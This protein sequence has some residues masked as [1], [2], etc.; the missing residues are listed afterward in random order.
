MINMDKNYHTPWWLKRHVRHEDAKKSKPS[1]RS[2]EFYKSSNNPG[3][4]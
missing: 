3:L 1:P 4:A 2:P